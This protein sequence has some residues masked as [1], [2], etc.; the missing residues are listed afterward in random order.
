MPKRMFAST[1]SRTYNHYVMGLTHSPLSYLGGS[2]LNPFQKQALV[3][4]CMQCRS[5]ANTVGKGE[6][7]HNEQFLLFQLFST[8]L[9]NFLSFHEIQNFNLQTLLS[10]VSLKFAVWE[11]VKTNKRRYN[12][13]F[14]G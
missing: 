1:G 5:L 8:C 7:A 6:I 12:I 9:K 2:L 10:L 14:E 3:F 11:R 13:N 4:T